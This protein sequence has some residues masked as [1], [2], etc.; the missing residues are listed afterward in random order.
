MLCLEKNSLLSKS[1][2]K[3]MK[4]YSL[5]IDL[6]YK[7][8]HRIVVLSI[9]LSA[10]LYPMSLGLWS[11]LVEKYPFI[12]EY[13]SRVDFVGILVSPLT[14]AVLYAVIKWLFKNF[15]WK[16][17]FFVSIFGVPNLNGK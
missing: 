16:I 15:L 9:L 6:R 14:M 10:F 13:I 5:N 4:P 12:L 17:H 7:I 3:Y 2:E 8:E 11:E 1:G